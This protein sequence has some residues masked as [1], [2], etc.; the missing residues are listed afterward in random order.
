MCAGRSICSWTARPPELRAPNKTES[1]ILS[2][3]ILVYLLSIGP[4]Y[5]LM[6]NGRIGKTAFDRTYGPVIW[7]HDTSALKMPIES[8]VKLWEIR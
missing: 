2:A 3:A 6:R 7:L 5:R 1:A 4:A 8:Y